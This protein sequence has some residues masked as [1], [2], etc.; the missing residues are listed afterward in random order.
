MIHKEDYISFI[1]SEQNI[2][3][4][5]TDH[6]YNRDI[7]GEI[8]FK[9]GDDIRVQKRSFM[10]M[11]DVFAIIGGYM[12]LFSTIFKII[13]LLSNK[14]NYDVKI[15]NGLFNIYPEKKKITLKYK[16]QS[17]LNE[18]QEQKKSKSQ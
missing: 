16:I 9:I 2:Y 8:Q 12:Q 14:L 17:K 4:R 15:I 10:K 1:K 7:M 11:T 18:F 13:S 5:N 3:Y 6:Y